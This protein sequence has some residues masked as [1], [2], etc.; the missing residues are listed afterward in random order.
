MVDE[1]EA[2]E[3]LQRVDHIVVLMMENRSFDHMLGYLSLPPERDGAGRDD[4]DGLHGGEVNEFMGREYGIEPFGDGQLAKL[5]DPCHS[6]WCVGQQMAHGMSGF[7]ANYATTRGGE[8]PGDVMRYQTAANVPV[9]DFLA[10]NYAVLDR[11]FCSI[12]GSTFPNRIASLAGEAGSLDNR[13]PPLYSRRSFVRSLPPTVSWRWYS[14]DPG[15]L[16]LIDD[17]YRVGWES[18]FAYVEKPSLVQPRTF[19]KDVLEGTLPNVSWIDPNFVDLG[20][21]HGADD[22]HPPTDVMAGQSFVLK[23]YQALTASRLWDRTMLVVVYD[24]HGGFYDHVD[25]ADGLPEEFASRAE[26][27]S[28]GPRVPALVVSPLVEP[29]AAFGSAQGGDPT[30]LFDHCA[31]IRT[32]MVRFAGGSNVGLP[33]RVA[34]SS[35]LGHVL[36]ADSPRDGIPDVF[37]AGVVQRVADWWSTAIAERLAYPMATVPALTELGVDASPSGAQGF[38]QGIWGA[39]NRVVD[40]LPWRRRRRGASA[41][42]AEAAPPAEAAAVQSPAQLAEPNELEAGM[43]EAAKHLRSGAAGKP[44]RPGQP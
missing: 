10:S 24:E 22:D 35:H 21:L 8:Q 37:E 1:R 15:M 44:L 20:G 5:H 40:L 13:M 18:N 34:S 38:L 43:L 23:V 2:R 32:I 33:E 25:P 12:P 36:T 6:G 4:V 11:W 30:L 26:F 19:Y 28:F 39:I 41:A 16:R 29:G 31:L 9:Y 27:E 14:S 3:R 17:R 42:G 7:V